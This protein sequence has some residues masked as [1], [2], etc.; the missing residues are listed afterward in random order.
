MLLI[1]G[2]GLLIGLA[3]GLTGGG[4]SIFAVPL[5]IYGLGVEPLSAIT[6]S[7]ATVTTVALFGAV[8]AIRSGVVELRV[9]T[10]FAIG[11][12]VAAPL[13]VKLAGYFSGTMILYSFS[14]LM[15]VVALVMWRNAK[16]NPQVTSVVRADYASPE[17]D[18]GPVCRLSSDQ[19]VTLSAPC[20][21]VLVVVGAVTGILAGFFGVGG[22]FVIVPALTLVTQLSIHRAVATSLYV[23]A[24]IGASGLG[25]AL[26]AGR[27]LPGQLTVLFTLGGVA[28]LWVG[29]KLAGRVAGPRLQQFFALMMIMV[30]AFIWTA[31]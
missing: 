17:A 16:R 2:F 31:E 1:V 27:E 15:V 22:G 13:G 29:R 25:S 4:G 19:R 24:L 6:L 7:L 21:L 20:S 3:L 18:G 10:I 9:G 23:I 8:G 14:V 26:L 12:V 5:L 30:V 11:G 28:G